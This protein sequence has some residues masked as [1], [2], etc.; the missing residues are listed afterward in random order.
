MKHTSR[1]FLLL[2]LLSKNMVSSNLQTLIEIVCVLKLQPL[3]EFH[4][5][6]NKKKVLENVTNE[7]DATNIKKFEKNLFF[8]TSFFV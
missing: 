1:S 2:N 6:I 4:S 5:D 8:N 7:L 3:H